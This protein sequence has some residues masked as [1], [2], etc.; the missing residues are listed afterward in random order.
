MYL[1]NME[2]VFN[3]IEKSTCFV[4]ALIITPNSSNSSSML[5]LAKN[6]IRIMDEACFFS[7]FQPD[8][9]LQY[10]PHLGIDLLETFNLV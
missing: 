9:P 7:F 6:N 10:I 5:Y 3:K 2:M 8:I 4:P 1:Y